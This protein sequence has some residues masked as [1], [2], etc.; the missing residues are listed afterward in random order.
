MDNALLRSYRFHRE[1]GGGIVGE[2]ALW[3]LR[4]ARAELLLDEAVDLGVAEVEW[5]DDD[6]PYDPGDVCT[7]QEAAEKFDSNEWTG[8]FGCILWIA[9]GFGELHPHAPGD[10]RASLWGIV[11]GPRGID[12]PYCRVVVADLALEVEDE[13][14]QAVGD[15]LDAETPS[16]I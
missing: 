11:V 3:A 6:V 15:A 1:H 14:R 8:P 9:D 13:L 12:D 2:S 7:R 4:A 5:L 16:L 10:A